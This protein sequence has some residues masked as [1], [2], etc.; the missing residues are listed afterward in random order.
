MVLKTY[1][2]PKLWGRKSKRH[3]QNPEHAIRLSVKSLNENAS[4]C[5]NTAHS[6]RW[7]SKVFKKLAQ[8]SIRKLNPWKTAQLHTT[9]RLTG[10]EIRRLSYKTQGSLLYSQDP[11]ICPYPKPDTNLLCG[12]GFMD[13][14]HRPKSKILKIL[15]N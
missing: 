12:E 14:I 6:E 13:F 10:Q 15:T 4:I 8:T 7:S 9:R 5:I 2:L 11:A 1:K 3:D